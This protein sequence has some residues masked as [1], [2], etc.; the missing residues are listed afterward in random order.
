MDDE[1]NS[2][3]S[4]VY[5][6]SSPTKEGPRDSL[7]LEGKRN[8]N[9]G[10][11]IVD[12]RHMPAGC[13]TWP[14]FW[15]TDEDNWPIN[16]E[17][18]VI[19]GVNTQDI[20][21]TSLH[22]TQHCTMDDVPPNSRKG[23]WDIAQGVPDD[24]GHVDMTAREV[25]D[26]FVWDPHQWLNEGCVAVSDEKGTLGAPLNKKGGGVF[27]L[28][29]DP[30]N[31]HIRTWVF[32]HNSTLPVNLEQSMQTASNVDNTTRVMPDPNL[33]GLPFGYFPIGKFEKIT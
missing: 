6:S 2:E 12:V 22:S 29:W 13:G 24:Y 3:E 31:H 4:F 23:T 16:G 8:F 30:I 18:D 33:W 5:M 21:K 1:S 19:E 27:I 17:I 20:A 15:L 10:L 28:E 26:C 9:R 11:F 14:A 32:T 7:R 25:T